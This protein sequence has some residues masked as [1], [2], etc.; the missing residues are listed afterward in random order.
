MSNGFPLPDV[1]VTG[2]SAQAVA[3]AMM[4]AVGRAEGKVNDDGHL[5]ADFEWIAD[6]YAAFAKLIANPR[7]R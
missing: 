2:D 1:H 3:Y 6:K 7:S 4:L 5:S